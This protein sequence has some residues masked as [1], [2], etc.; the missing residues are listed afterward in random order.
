V[1]IDVVVYALTGLAALG[2]AWTAVFGTSNRG[3]AMARAPRRLHLVAGVLALI[4]WVLFLFTDSASLPQRELIGIGA[5]FFWWLVVGA[6]LLL[7]V[8]YLPSRGRHAGSRAK[9]RFSPALVGVFMHLM[10]LVCVG[11]FTYAYMVSAV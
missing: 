7:L 11:V 5:L 4:G 8:Q 6:G 9:R 1:S 3:V 2:I 10:M